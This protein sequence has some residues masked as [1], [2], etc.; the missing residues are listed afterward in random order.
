MRALSDRSRLKARAY[1]FLL[2]TVPAVFTDGPASSNKSGGD[3]PETAML[4][5]FER[6]A[7]VEMSRV[8]A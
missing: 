7:S 2:G 6:P 5:R 1:P 4:G 8:T 3:H